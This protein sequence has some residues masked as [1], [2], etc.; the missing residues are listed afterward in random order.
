MAAITLR[1]RCEVLESR[2]LMAADLGAPLSIAVESSGLEGLRAAEIQLNYDPRSLNIEAADIRPGA[3]WKEQASLVTNV[4]AD[5]GSVR[6][7]LFSIE[8]IDTQRGKLVDLHFEVNEG[9]AIDRSS[10]ALSHI[11]LNEGELE[12][13]GELTQLEAKAVDTHVSKSG[14]TSKDATSNV[15]GDANSEVNGETS[16]TIDKTCSPWAWPATTPEGNGSNSES[17]LA[18]LHGMTEATVFPGSTSQA[19]LWQLAAPLVK[20]KNLNPFD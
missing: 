12:S 13:R 11:R 14:E 8:P 17:G 20:L 16:I 1:L 18:Q 19:D 5:A 10:V 6:I 3:A 9:N 4:D 2:R 15:E 7:F